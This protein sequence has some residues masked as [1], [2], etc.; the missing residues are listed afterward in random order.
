MDKI[1]AKLTSRKLWAALIG[2]A[3]GIAMVFGLDEG[4]MSTTCGAVVTIASLITYIVTEGKVDAQAV[5][6]KFQQLLQAA[7]YEETKQNDEDESKRDQT[8]QAV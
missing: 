8:D 4:I 6:E 3:A 2:A 1:I 7:A 5:R